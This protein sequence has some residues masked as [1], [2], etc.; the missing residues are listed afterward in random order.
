MA[1]GRDVARRAEL[2]AAGEVMDLFAR[3]AVIALDLYVE[4]LPPGRPLEAG[5][6]FA[7]L[8]RESG[9]HEVEFPNPT[10]SQRIL[11]AAYG[12]SQTSSQRPLT[13]AGATRD[14]SLAGRPVTE[15]IEDLR[16]DLEDS[17]GDSLEVPEPGEWLKQSLGRLAKASVVRDAVQLGAA[18]RLLSP[19]AREQVDNLVQ[20][21]LRLK[22]ARREVGR[23]A[24][25]YRAAS[26]RFTVDRLKYGAVSLAATSIVM[27]TPHWTGIA[28]AGRAVSVY[29]ALKVFPSWANRRSATKRLD[30]GQ[31]Q[32]RSVR[33]DVADVVDRTKPLGPL[34]QRAAN[35]ANR[36]SDGPSR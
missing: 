24:D 10:D 27:A 30:A 12:L 20:Q 13:V 22:D 9:L 8:W 26:D 15:G 32:L 6:R 5:E 19:A 21:G 33:A 16:R 23:S 25:G 7:L 2:K 18:V 11:R 3:E 4:S 28:A 36:R 35:I 1:E 34:A 31:E 29:A 17:Y 14:A